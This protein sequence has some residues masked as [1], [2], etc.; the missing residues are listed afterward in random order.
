VY[1][2]NFTV[3]TRVDTEAAVVI[4]SGE[5]DLRTSTLLRSELRK[6]I[7]RTTAG[8]V[9]LDASD[10]GFVSSGGLA[11]L[12][13]AAQ[14]AEQCHKRFRVVTGGHQV[15]PRTLRIAGLDR[16]VSTCSTY[17]DAIGVR[18]IAAPPGSDH[19]AVPAAHGLRTP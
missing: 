7:E 3:I 10:V 8:L 19:E 5:I 18:P 14:R 15:I 16:L 9:V 1:E 4:A 11:V 17:A 6:A 2:E 12:V 13:T